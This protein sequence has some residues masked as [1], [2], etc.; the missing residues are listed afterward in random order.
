MSAQLILQP[1]DFVTEKIDFCLVW[2]LLSD[3]RDT[4]GRDIR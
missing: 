3:S 1:F 2:Q 4:C